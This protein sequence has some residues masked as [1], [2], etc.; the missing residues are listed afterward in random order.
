MSS[1]MCIVR[2]RDYPGDAR[3]ENQVQA[4]VDAGYDVDVLCMRRSGEPYLTVENG[5]RLYRLPSLE[6]QRGGKLRYVAEYLAFFALSFL[7]LAVLQVRRKY[8][9]VQVCNL[10]DFLVFTA[11]VPKMLGA[12]VVLDL[13]ESTP[14]FYHVKFGT[15]LD[16]HVMRALVAV[17][18]WSIRFADVALT[19]TEQMRRAFAGRGARPDRMHVMLNSPNPEFVREPA[20]RS[21]TTRADGT[22]R[23]VTHGTITE[24]YGHDVLIRAMPAVLKKVPGAYLEIYGAGNRREYLEDVV[25]KCS[26]SDAVN[27]AGYLPLE[28][29]I[30]RLQLADCGIVPMPRNMESDLIHTH[31]MQEYMVLGV[32]VIISR[33]KAVEY[34]FDD[35]CVRFFESGNEQDLAQAIID[36]Y[37]NPEARY[38]LAKN[39]LQVYER[40]SARTQR[41]YY[42][43]LVQGLVAETRRG[44]QG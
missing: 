3:I 25:E 10:P 43:R 12:R 24:R 38:Q 44:L 42:S 27:F 32:P 11:F 9:L 4:L 40:Y 6:R 8:A 7:M 15:R 1:R 14:E 5:V 21:P 23:I 30:N 35:T 16:G 17:E 37:E 13:R 29:L 2:H 39:A 22:F 41:D 19:C 20:L 33:T 28:E 36:L 31:K 34:Y 18:Q 26:L